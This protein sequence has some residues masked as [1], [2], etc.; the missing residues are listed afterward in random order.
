MFDTSQ[1]RTYKM[2]HY[3]THHMTR[4]MTHHMTHHRTHHNK[5]SSP[6]YRK[7]HMTH[8]IARERTHYMTHHLTDKIRGR[9]MDTL[10]ETPQE[11]RHIAEGH[12]LYFIVIV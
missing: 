4:H 12:P 11:T 2:T 8:H 7:C 1:R 9:P 5:Y 6:P 10:Q 3:R